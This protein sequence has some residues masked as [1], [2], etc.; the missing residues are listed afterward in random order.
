MFACFWNICWRNYDRVFSKFEQLMADFEVGTKTTEEAKVAIIDALAT[1]GIT[2]HVRSLKRAGHTPISFAT[3]GELADALH[4]AYNPL[5]MTD[6]PENCAS[7]SS[8]VFPRVLRGFPS[9]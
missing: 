9:A 4:H 3:V 7:S 6:P 5:A 1:F 8:H 2:E